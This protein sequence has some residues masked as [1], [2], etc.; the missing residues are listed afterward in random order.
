MI[1]TN[2]IQKTRSTLAG[3]KKQKKKQ[4]LNGKW[5]LCQSDRLHALRKFIKL[6]RIMGNF[7]WDHPP[8]IKKKREI[9]L[10]E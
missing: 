8:T 3:G 2:E 5:L 10:M 4:V 6:H 1:M 7:W 9:G